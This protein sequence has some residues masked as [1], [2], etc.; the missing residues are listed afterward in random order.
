M[1]R[2]QQQRQQLLVVVVVVLH[3]LWS[4]IY[5]PWSHIGAGALGRSEKSIEIKIRPGNTTL[6]HH[7]RRSCTSEMIQNLL[8]KH[9]SHRR[10]YPL[11]NSI[12]QPPRSHNSPTR[13]YKLRQFV[14]LL[15]TNRAVIVHTDK[16][17]CCV[18]GFCQSEDPPTYSEKR[19]IEP[20]KQHRT[21]INDRHVFP[22]YLTGLKRS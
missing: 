19:A 6:S 22:S 14:C 17:A 7:I 8:C 3:Y 1:V 2:E 10:G 15:R 5:S 4:N 21:N 12:G 9:N 16:C 11:N 13:G 18:L 20:K